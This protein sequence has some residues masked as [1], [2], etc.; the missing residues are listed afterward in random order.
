MPEPEWKYGFEVSVTLVNE[1]SNLPTYFTT[2]V[3]CKT[4][5]ELIESLKSLP[6]DALAEQL[7]FPIAM[8]L[9]RMPQP[10]LETGELVR[11]VLQPVK[12]KIVP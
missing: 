1:Q 7:G 9:S 11:W 2:Q 12:P 10:D 5:A 8:S 3:E 4:F 6:F